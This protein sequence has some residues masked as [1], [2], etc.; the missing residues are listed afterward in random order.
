M[1]QVY[2]VAGEHSAQR[3]VAAFKKTILTLLGVIAA[4]CVGE[5]VL[6][7]VLFLRTTSI[8]WSVMAAMLLIAIC[9][10]SR[11][12]MRRVEEFEKQRLSYRAG[13]L[14]EYEV[15]IE[16][17]GLSDQFTVFNN[18]N[19]KRGNL[20]HVVVGPTGLFAIETKN[21]TGLISATADGELKR[22]GK[23]ATAPHVRKFL[24]R[25]MMVR[26]QAMV[27]TRSDDFYI[28]A[29]MVFP[30]AHVEAPYGSTGKVHCVRLN[31]L[32]DYIDDPRFS[33]KLSKERV[34][35]LIRAL[36]GIACMD[37]DF[38]DTA[39][40]GV[41]RIPKGHAVLDATIESAA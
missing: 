16:L 35:E 9:W 32:R 18:V 14:G 39:T 3:S 12:A 24:S 11:Y 38:S 15:A 28:R 36:Q 4:L 7:A 34:D 21:W 8:P 10:A 33:A 29:V 17:E 41:T 40:A 19:T 1:A 6:A 26:E 37:V 13:F 20:D 5:G 22:N 30:K 25:A 31:R 2:G 27:L 23:D